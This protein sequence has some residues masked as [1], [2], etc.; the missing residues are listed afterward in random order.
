MNIINFKRTLYI[1][2]FIFGLQACGG[3]DPSTSDQGDLSTPDQTNSQQKTTFNVTVNSIMLT[4]GASTVA[5]ATPTQSKSKSQFIFNSKNILP[6]ALKS[7]AILS[8][9]IANENFK[10]AIIDAAGI[11]K[12]EI[13][14]ESIIQK[15]DETF[16]IVLPG[17]LRLDCVMI[18]DVNGVP[19]LT[20]G[21]LLPADVL[22]APIVSENITL[23]I[24]STETFRKLLQ[25]VPDVANIVT[26]SGFTLSEIEDVINQVRDTVLASSYNLN[27]DVISEIIQREF[28]IV[29]NGDTNYS[30]SN[31]YST[32][33]YLNYLFGFSAAH[34]IFI[35]YTY[36]DE[37]KSTGFSQYNWNHS[38]YAFELNNAA[39][40]TSVE[41]VLTA[42]GWTPYLDNFIITEN[43][44]G[45]V[46]AGSQSAAD[47][48]YKLEANYRLDVSEKP[49]H[50]Y[51]A[52]GNYLAWSTVIPQGTVFGQ[53]ADIYR[54]SVTNLNDIV[55]F[56][57]DLYYQLKRPDDTTVTS[58]SEIQ[59]A[60]AATNIVTDMNLVMIIYNI[61]AEF[62]VGGQV[63]FYEINVESNVA[64]FLSSGTWLIKTLHG[65]QLLTINESTLINQV[66]E[67]DFSLAFALHEGIVYQGAIYQAGS[68]NTS[69]IYFNHLAKNELVNA[70]T[71]NAQQI[72]FQPQTHTSRKL[73]ATG[74]LPVHLML[75]I[76]YGI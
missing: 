9:K 4:T 37:M 50:D 63:N 42:N 51:L 20:I 76:V 52:G 48:A 47:V 27:I 46:T 73:L 16:N 61:A 64:S 40:Y 31:L 23:D 10:V 13:V 41:Y 14:L 75:S 68:V 24:I 11:V 43:S 74:P 2:F 6:S 5:D 54:T 7:N 35:N 49:V 26:D 29:A 8:G 55:I 53:G 17:G 70:F 1:L 59:T 44:D 60:I 21:E 3:S 66:L 32:A 72:S 62:V 39:Q 28:D 30:L 15:P 12:E 25:L 36:Y 56:D 33:G 22:Y 57:F 58:L 19:A 45:S 38:N 67:T 34:E 18:V 69:Q 65:Q 71:T